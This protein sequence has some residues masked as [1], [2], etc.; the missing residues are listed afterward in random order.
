M[1]IY[2]LTADEL[3]KNYRSR[4]L[5]PVEVVKE[6]FQF[7]EEKNPQINAFVTLDKEGAIAQAEEA[8]QRYKEGTQLLPLD[9][10]PVAIKDLVNT[11]GIRT[12][13][14][15]LVYK[16]HIADRDATVVKRL[17]DAGAII[18]GKTNT[19]EFGFKG[20]T[21]NPLFGATR[22]PWN[23]DYQ[24]GGSS[25]GSAAAIAS[26]F[27]PL[28]QGG[29]GGG[30][31][32]IPAS[33][34]GV[35]GFKPTFGRIPLDNGLEAVYG[36]HNPFIHYGPISR[37]VTDAALMFDVIQG[38]APTDPFSLPKLNIS[39]YDTLQKETRNEFV[40]GYTL[41]FGIFEIENETKEAF[42]QTIEKFRKWGLRIEPVEIPMNKTFEEYVDF[43]DKVWTTHLS[44]SAKPL[45]ENHADELS[46]GL[47]KLIQRAEGLSAIE[48]DG[49]GE[50]RSY[51]FHTMQNLFQTYDVIITPTLVSSNVTY[52]SYSPKMINGY[53]T[54]P[55]YDYMLLLTSILNLTGQPGCSLPI[56][57]TD[58][59]VPIG[60]QAICKRFNDVTMF[61]FAK[62]VEEHLNT[63]TLARL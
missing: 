23:I 39:I 57:F 46:E 34:C 13:Y 60:M 47:K 44:A 11:E 19:P 52:D 37:T 49:L 4:K 7:I 15:C 41:D 58:K 27:I 42:L 32:R 62:W 30:S 16:D 54:N 14:G 31:I 43:F 59:G 25:G 10:V 56:G 17:K 61:Q 48:F 50:Y 12:T 35:Y 53:N 21:E 55:D 24:T 3:L 20:V 9:G 45:L 63:L 1:K 6:L 18:M 22:N 51:L 38:D 36:N 29:D 40:I 5:S 28:A 33:L 2:E 26:G 8:E